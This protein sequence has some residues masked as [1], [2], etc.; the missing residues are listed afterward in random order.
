MK[1]GRDVHPDRTPWTVREE[2]A[3]PTKEAVVSSDDV[4]KEFGARTSSVSRNF[5]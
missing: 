4:R 5:Q 2:D 1:E 3:H